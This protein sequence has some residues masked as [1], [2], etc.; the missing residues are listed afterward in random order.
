MTM[1]HN[2]ARRVVLSR[3]RQD[4]IG[5]YSEDELLQDNPTDVYMSGILY[6]QK[7]TYSAEEPDEGAQAGE[8]GEEQGVPS[9]QNGFRPSSIGLS[10]AVRP[11]D[12]HEALLRVNVDLARYDAQRLAPEQRDF[13]WQRIPLTS[14]WTIEIPGGSDKKIKNVPNIQGLGYWLRCRRHGG[15]YLVTVVLVNQN[16]HVGGAPA[17]LRDIGSFHQV[18]MSILAEP[19]FGEIVPKPQ[20]GAE[21]PDPER[22]SAELL[23]RGAEEYAV[24]HTTAATWERDPEQGIVLRT[25][26]LPQVEVPS[27]SPNGDD[28]YFADVVRPGADF[29]LGA[30]W[31]STTPEA[32]LLS[33]LRALGTCYSAWI[34]AREAEISD[35]PE[36]HREAAAA[37][38]AECRKAVGRMSE[39]IE[40]LAGDAQ[41]LSAF[42]WANRA[43]WLQNEWKRKHDPKV[44]T[45]IWRPFQL[46]FVLLCL[47]STARAEDPARMVM[48]LL[49][50]PTGGGKTEAYLLLTAFQ[51][52]HRRLQG[53]GAADA[54]GVTVFMRYTLRLLTA[55]QFQRAA[56][57]ILACDMIR[58][59]DHICPGSPIP[60]H[61]GNDPAISIGLWV[62]RDT[63][64]NKISEVGVTSSP[65][66]VAVCP[67]CGCDLEWG[68]SDDGSR[69][70]ARCLSSD[71]PANGSAGHLPFWSVDV[72]VYRELPS[73]L[74]GTADKFVQIV[75]KKETGRLFGLGDAGRQPPDLIIQDELHLIAGPLGSMAG[76]FET[77]IDELCA[78]G[79]RRPKIIGSTATIRRADEQIGALFDRKSL[80][81]PPPGLD[82][83]NSGFSVTESGKPG[84]LYVGVT[85]SGR[86]ASYIYQAI[87]A[88]VLQAGCD[89][90]IAPDQ[91]DYYWTLV[92][93]FNA[94]RELGSA[95]I[96]MQDD[97]DHTL[98]LLANRR[99][100]ASRTLQPPLE[101]TSRVKSDE[102]KDRLRELEQTKAGGNA[103]DVVLASNM[104]SVGM[105][106]PRLGLMLVNGQP[107]T[108][109]EY[110]QAT[111]RVGRGRTPGLVLTLYNA[112]KMRDRSRYEGFSTW[113]RALYRDVEATGVTPFAPR[114]RDKALH[115]PFV[116]MVRHLVPGMQ[117]NPSAVRAN[118]TGIRQ[119]IE[120]ICARVSSVDGAEAEAARNELSAFLDSWLKRGNL[121]KYWD[122][123]SDNALLVAAETAAAAKASGFSEGHAKPTPNTLRAVESSTKF[124]IVEKVAEEIIE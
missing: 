34:E 122:N 52:F 48:D 96:I 62:G 20:I 75:S 89:I 49:W 107:K 117:D 102:I 84:R 27:A 11:I 17:G 60:P 22:Q 114:A 95:S 63:T 83:S 101:L 94:L 15:L 109:A 1:E 68:V 54:A 124:V 45:L 87:A 88:S 53:R 43:L 106:I 6:A 86:S 119:V 9:P 71:C 47:K 10:F 67:D 59:A 61:F 36:R 85:S 93:Y 64:P 72:D 16:R 26:W 4:L 2:S 70:L 90:A 41:A 8:N 19:G 37:H 39:G 123:W 29:V 120:K 46:A 111:S 78:R 79:A 35:L 100:E 44:G 14:T 33:G 92:C 25:D 110:I 32:G 104:I 108:I 77:A 55:Q 57:M 121:T 7:T 99:G 18:G 24:G 50:F 82:Q 31:L 91:Q 105:D 118:E 38:M 116:A 12:G 42:R 66:Q 13:T 56:A 81:F 65:A 30:E 58:R 98:G 28:R 80:Q 113:H 3:L 76:L 51:I 21:F 40:L 5:P 112:N 74:I 97:V 115:A 73:L 103:A 23:Y 69:V